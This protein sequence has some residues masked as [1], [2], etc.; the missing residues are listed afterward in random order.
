[1]FK[2]QFEVEVQQPSSFTVW[3]LAFVPY[4]IAYHKASARFVFLHD[5]TAGCC[6]E[7]QHDHCKRDLCV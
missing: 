7:R 5:D 6:G 2:F 1:M 3:P 4:Q